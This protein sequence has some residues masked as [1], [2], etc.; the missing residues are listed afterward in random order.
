MKI[1]WSPRANAEL[2]AEIEWIAR[3][4]PQ[5]AAAWLRRIRDATFQLADFP[6][7][8][9]LLREFPDSSYRELVVPPYRIVYLSD[10]DD[11][12]IITLKHSRERLSEIDL[13]PDPG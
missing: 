8:G 12:I 7:R 2:E 1:I 6:G 13:R 3:E 9:K 5:T 10:P 4:R 11:L